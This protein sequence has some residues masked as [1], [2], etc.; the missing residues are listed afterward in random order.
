MSNF[1]KVQDLEEQ[2]KKQRSAASSHYEELIQTR[3]RLNDCN[4]KL[5]ELES[6]NAHLKVH[7]KLPACCIQFINHAPVHGIYF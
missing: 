2:M 1:S 3:S 4:L 7:I 6:A 5:S